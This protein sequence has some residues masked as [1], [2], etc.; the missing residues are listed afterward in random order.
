MDLF[1]R[2]VY[3]GKV[4]PELRR[5]KTVRHTGIPVQYVRMGAGEPGASSEILPGMWK[6]VR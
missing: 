6:S 4:L 5:Q 1:L 2:D 3:Y